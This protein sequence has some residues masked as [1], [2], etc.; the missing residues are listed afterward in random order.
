MIYTAIIG[1]KDTRRTDIQCFENDYKFNNYRL[2]ARMY[3]ILSHLF[4]TDEWSI[5]I[6]GNIHLFVS[7]DDLIDMTKPY[8]VGV[9]KHPERGCIYEEGEFCKKIGKGDNSIIDKQLDDYRHAGYLENN[10][11]GATYILVRK[12]IPEINKLNEKW[13]SH[14]CRYSIRDQISFPFVF[15]NHV[16]Y[17]PKVSMKQNHYFKRVKHAK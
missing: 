2:T 11:L 3:K 13:W 17:F 10:G 7:K 8:N 9:F 14:V 12:N 15:N 4:I 5:W 1:E 6:D 16:K